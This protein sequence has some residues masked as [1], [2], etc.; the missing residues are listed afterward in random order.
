MKHPYALDQFYVDKQASSEGSKCG[1]I[2]WKNN[3]LKHIVKDPNVRDDRQM[4][5]MQR[6]IR[7]VTA[8]YSQQ[9]HNDYLNTQ[10]QHS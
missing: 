9:A 3:Y 7:H 6:L 4:Y 2:F 10:S 8:A 5:E 1:D